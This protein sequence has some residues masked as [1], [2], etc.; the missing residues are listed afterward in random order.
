MKT[1]FTHSHLFSDSAFLYFCNVSRLI[2]AV[3]FFSLISGCFI[4][5]TQ[6]TDQY[7]GKDDNDRKHV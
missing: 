4:T 7:I 6:L 1:W 2:N 5:I 3:L